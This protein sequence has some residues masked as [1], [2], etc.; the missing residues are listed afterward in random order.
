MRPGPS[1]AKTI[2][3][4]TIKIDAEPKSAIDWLIEIS[5]AEGW[6]SR[7]DEAYEN[8]EKWRDKFLSLLRQELSELNKIGRFA[9]FDFN[10][11]SDYFIQGC[12]FVE[13]KDSDG[14]KIAKRRR[15]QYNSY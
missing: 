1:S 15:T 3:I 8:A 12:A 14:V 9:S 4:S 5:L 10:S 13:P 11:S 2:L 6:Y 7:K